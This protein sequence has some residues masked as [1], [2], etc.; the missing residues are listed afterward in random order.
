MSQFCRL[1]VI[2]Y[3]KSL[4]PVWVDKFGLTS[5]QWFYHPL[6]GYSAVGIKGIYGCTVMMVISEK[7]GYISHIWE[8]PVF[9]DHNFNPSDDDSFTM[10][11]FNALRDGTIYVQSVAALIGTDQ[12]PGVLNAIYAP[13]VFVF[14]PF[15]TEWDRLNFGIS[16]TLR[17]QSRAEALAQKIAGIIPGSGGNG[18]TVGYTR[19]SPQSSSQEA[20]IAGRVI[21]EV[22]PFQTWFTAP[23]DSNSAGLQIGRWRLWVEDQL[24]TYQDF[25]LPHNTAP[26]GSF[27]SQVSGHTSLC[28]TCANSP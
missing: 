21:L 27:Q 7:G 17:Y 4:T 1:D 13:K 8:E 2:S 26:G 9:V 24:I 19:T 12:N 5:G 20:G 28:S 10:N 23:R 11:T 16:T 15:T 18:I 3:V 25:W 6:I 22:E 14:T